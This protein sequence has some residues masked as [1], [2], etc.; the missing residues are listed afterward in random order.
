MRSRPV[1]NIQSCIGAEKARLVEPGRVSSLDNIN[2]GQIDIA[3]L[4]D[5]QY[6]CVVG[7]DGQ[8]LVVQLNVGIT[9]GVLAGDVVDQIHRA[10][11]VSRI[12]CQEAIV[13]NI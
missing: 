4:G 1:G 12:I 3:A 5:E 10:T 9:V 13:L 11:T 2:M 8:G 6:T 7:I